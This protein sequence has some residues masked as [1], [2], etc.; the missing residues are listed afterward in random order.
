MKRF[1]L[2]VAVHNLEAN[3]G[4]YS[5]VFGQQ[6]TVV[7]DDYAKWMLE[8]PRINFAISSRG[9]KAGVDH[10]GLQVDS[11]EELAVLRA[12]VGEAEIAARDQ[13]DA[14]CCYSNSNKYWITD[15][16]GIA[17]ETYHTLA[18]IPTFG[19]DAKAAGPDAGSAVASACCAPKKPAE[20]AG[21]KRAACC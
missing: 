14:A 9:L 10:L 19:K 6:P 8:D 11:D 1:H 12:Q 3:I 2:H 20:P 15:P 7:K 18:S 17:W 16:Q 4:F 21:A 5:A 13:P